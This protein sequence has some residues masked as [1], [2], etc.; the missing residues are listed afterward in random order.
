MSYNTVKVEL[1][2]FHISL[3]RI[4]LLVNNTAYVSV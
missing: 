4:Y 1:E 2:R 3:H